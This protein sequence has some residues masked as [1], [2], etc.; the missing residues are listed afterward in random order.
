MTKADRNTT[1]E[2]TAQAGGPFILDATDVGI[3][4]L[5]QRNCKQPLAE[6]GKHVELSAPAV[7]ERVHKLEDAGV[8]RAYRAEID[9]RA[10]GKDI[11]AFIGVSIEH[12]RAV[13]SFE[14]D[15]DSVPDVLE[16]HHVTGQHTLML[17]VKTRNT[18][19]LERL[20]DQI[21]SVNG[22]TRTETQVVLSTCAERTE[23][24]FEVGDAPLA[25]RGRRTRVRESREGGVR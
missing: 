17:K 25:K 21:R 16:C 15:I 6:I 1:P 10:I 23:L 14:K 4:V 8:I 12:P 13:E 3:L 7:M 9:G 22:V 5:L 24:A 18:E 19:S 20:I 11:T 2:S